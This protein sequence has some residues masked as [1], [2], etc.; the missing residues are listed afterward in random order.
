MALHYPTH[1]AGIASHHFLRNALVALVF[2]AA[3]VVLVVAALLIRPGTTTPTTTI[4]ESQSLADFRAG[5]RSTL[6]EFAVPGRLPRRRAHAALKVA[7]PLSS[8]PATAGADRGRRSPPLRR[9]RSLSVTKA[10]PA[11][12]R[13]VRATAR[14]RHG[15]LGR[16][17]DGPLTTREPFDVSAR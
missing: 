17:L 11:G 2:V 4:P 9:P 6:F 13:P 16:P 8:V 15:P 5:E 1:P 12:W 7:N 3:A 14:P 10:L